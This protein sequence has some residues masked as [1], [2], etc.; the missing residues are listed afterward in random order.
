MPHCTGYVHDFLDVIVDGL[1]KVNPKHRIPCG[2]VVNKLRTMYRLCKDNIPYCIEQ[3][4]RTKTLV[5]AEL[6]SK[7]RVV[8]DNIDRAAS[9]GNAV[10]RRTDERSSSVSFSSVSLGG[11]QDVLTTTTN[12]QVQAVNHDSHDMTT[13]PGVTVTPTADSQNEPSRNQFLINRTGLTNELEH[14]RIHKD[15]APLRNPMSNPVPQERGSVGLVSIV[16]GDEM[17]LDSPPSQRDRLGTK[18]DRGGETENDINVS[19]SAL[20]AE[21][22]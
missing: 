1:L 6:S 5:R 12:A 10:H 19:T 7:L 13:V 3:K 8:Y 9:A 4:P 21:R 15:R 16:D 17:K 22:H 14:V 20:S 11:T 18:R 2:Q